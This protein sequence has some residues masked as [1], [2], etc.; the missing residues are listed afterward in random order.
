MP[1]IIV[2]FNLKPDADPKAY[3]NWARS[4]DLPTVRKLS[5]IGSF[6][7]LRTTSMLGSQDSP[8]YQYIEVIKVKDMA[9]FG[10]EVSTETMRKVASEFRGFADA[11]QFIVCESLD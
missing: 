9:A 8:P 2:L 5:S 1:H 7:A 11:P 6:D 3:E 4:T 10:D